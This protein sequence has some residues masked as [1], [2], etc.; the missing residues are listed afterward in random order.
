MEIIKYIMKIQVAIYWYQK[1]KG[2]ITKL[3]DD[4]HYS[5]EE[6]TCTCTYWHIDNW[7]VKYTWISKLLIFILI[8]K[9]NISL[10]ENRAYGNFLGQLHV[11][12]FHLL[13]PLF[14]L[15]DINQFSMWS[16]WA[17]TTTTRKVVERSSFQHSENLKIEIYHE[18]NITSFNYGSHFT[19]SVWCKTITCS[20]VACLLLVG[21]GRLHMW[22]RGARGRIRVLLC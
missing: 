17:I 22:G 20:T 14:D 1:V 12:R 10:E 3:R 2:Q 13:K 5:S 18:S 8:L 9:R 7:L 6:A 19:Y 16:T 4:T 21:S 15:F 11:M